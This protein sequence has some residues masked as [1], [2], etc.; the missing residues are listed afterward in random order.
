MK[1][2]AKAAL[3]MV[4]LL[5]IMQVKEKVEEFIHTVG[6][7]ELKNYQ[8]KWNL[9]KLFPLRI[10]CTLRYLPSYNKAFEVYESALNLEIPIGFGL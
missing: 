9:P 5:E 4:A 10:C 6:D 2:K 1:K 7:H 3:S 8:L